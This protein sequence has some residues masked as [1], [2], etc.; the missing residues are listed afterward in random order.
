[1]IEM[2]PIANRHR[3]RSGGTVLAV[4]ALLASACSLTTGRPAASTAPGGGPSTA[5]AASGLPSSLPVASAAPTQKPP[6][7][8]V[9]AA[10]PL[11]PA[12]KAAWESTVEKGQLL[13]EPVLDPSGNIWA[14]VS[15]MDRFAIT[16]KD[17]AAKGTWGTSGS[18]PG[19][20]TFVSSGNGWGAA[21]FRSDG[22]FV[23]ADSGNNR[24]QQFDS[25]R[26]LVKSWGEFGTKDGQLIDPLDVEVDGRNRVYVMCDIRHD[27][28]VFNEDG[29]FIRLLATNVGPYLDVAADGTAYVIENN[30][31]PAVDVFA[32]DGTWTATWDLHNF[33]S[34]A[35]DIEVTPSGRIF[36]A[37]SDTGGEHPIYKNLVELDRTGRAVH[38]WP[39][40]A[41]GI[42]VNAAQDRL[43]ETFSDQDSALLALLLPTK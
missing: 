21:A 33:A 36:V 4:I 25:N 34:F 7:P 30:S 14:P 35:T 6:T 29:T 37:S 5:P 8:T 32:P 12:L 41:E 13:F 23:V 10:I 22:G 16:T 1:V 3:V 42:A 18:D 11:E 17:G 24:I 43:Y 39:N 2:T 38:Y 26:R 19:Q 31:V 20:F 9:V 40:G 15:Y 28:Q 27:T